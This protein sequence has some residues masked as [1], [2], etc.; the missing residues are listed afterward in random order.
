MTKS[1]ILAF[2]QLDSKDAH[3]NCNK[4][5]FKKETYFLKEHSDSYSKY[6]VD[7][8][9]KMLEFLVNNIF[10]LVFFFRKSLSTDSRHSNGNTLYVS[11]LWS[12]WSIEQVTSPVYAF[13]ISQPIRYVSACSFEWFTD[14]F[15]ARLLS[16]K[17]LNR[18]YSMLR[19]VSNRGTG[20]VLPYSNVECCGEY[21][22]WSHDCRVIIVNGHRNIQ[23]Y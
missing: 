22:Q 9:I 6:T 2:Y 14:S 15:K 11:Y 17:L 3:S 1:Y 18:G 19:N 10:V 4:F 20:I 12:D 13:F 5:A 21:S 16:N 7:D 23:H 8:M